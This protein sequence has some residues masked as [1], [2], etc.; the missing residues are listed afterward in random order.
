MKCLIP[1]LTV[2]SFKGGKPVFVYLLICVHALNNVILMQYMLDK[3]RLE[4]IINLD[5]SVGRDA[6]LDTGD[7]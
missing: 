6:Y 1:P 3:T 2:S 4:L 5:K 7:L